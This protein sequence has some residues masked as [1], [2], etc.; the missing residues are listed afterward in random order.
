[1][2]RLRLVLLT[3]RYWPHLGDAE[4]LAA[5]IAGGLRDLDVRATVLTGSWG[6][7]WPP[8]LV[9]Q[10]INVAR[11]PYAPR[12]GWST[13][14]YL[15]ALTRWLRKHQ[16]EFDLAYVLNLRYEAYVTIQALRETRIPTVLHC[17]DGGTI[18]DGWWQSHTRFGSRIQRNCQQA[19]AIVTPNT[20]VADELV[21]LGYDRVRI[22]TIPL[23]VRSDEPRSA[24]RRFR[25]RVALADTN[26][27]LATAEYTPVALY[28]GRLDDLA[29]LSRLLTDWGAVAERWPSARL[30]LVGEG[31]ARES[32][33]EQLVDMDLRYQVLLP[34]AFDDWADLFQ[35]A[36]IYISPMAHGGR[37]MLLEAMAAGLP[38]VAADAADL[39]AMMERGQHGLLV[40]GQT[41]GA[42]TVAIS[43]LFESPQW[44]AELGAAGARL[45]AEHFSRRQ[46]AVSHLA[47]FEQ[48]VQRGR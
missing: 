31:S 23:G 4:C 41:P 8:S 27:D 1:M 35:A 47:L 2:T 44:A 18:G 36:D 32:L 24:D 40:A 15:R 25:A 21:S 22:H 20:W 26:H 5:S 19:A 17:Q 45:V 6:A 12:G 14:R 33:W 9:V 29:G 16:R 37:Q 43:R 3:S 7:D 34:G 46:M 39:R 11:V 42:W 30:W 13:F 10:D 38:I 28:V 48:C